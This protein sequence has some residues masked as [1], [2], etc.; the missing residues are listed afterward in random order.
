MCFLILSTSLFLM[1]YQDAGFEFTA[2]CLFIWGLCCT[3]WAFALA[4]TL[5]LFDDFFN[6]KPLI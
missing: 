4:L 3:L 5:E 2:K 6:K 1:A